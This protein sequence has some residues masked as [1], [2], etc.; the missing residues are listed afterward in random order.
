MHGILNGRERPR[1]PAQERRERH[2]YWLLK[3]VFE[4]TGPNADAPIAALEV[5]EALG[6]SRE[7][8]FRLIQFLA[9]N[10]YLHY[11]AAGPRVR[12]SEKGIRYLTRDARRRRSIRD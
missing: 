1:D 5:G 4:R 12:I 7:D 8:T 10:G 3:G 6:L 9:H 2:R 11:V